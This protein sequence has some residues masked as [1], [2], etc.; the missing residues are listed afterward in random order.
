[1]VKNKSRVR[2]R[3]ISGLQLVGSRPWTGFRLNCICWNMHQVTH[4][5]AG[6]VRSRLGTSVPLRGKILLSSP[7]IPL[8]VFQHISVGVSIIFRFFMLLCSRHVLRFSVTSPLGYQLQLCSTTNF[9]FGDEEK[10]IVELTK[11]WSILHVLTYLLAFCELLCRTRH[12]FPSGGRNHHK[13]SLHLSTEGWPGWVHGPERSGTVDLLRPPN[14]ARCS[15]TIVDVTNTDASTTNQPP[16]QT[17]RHVCM[18]W[19][20]FF[21]RICINACIWICP[22]KLRVFDSLLALW[23]FKAKKWANGKF[24]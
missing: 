3:A 19:L 13:Y 1:M 15:L 10:I 16:V 8:S 22:Y 20:K 7:L 6:I 11:V 12:F 4:S 24:I 9:L 21:W 18:F 2:V 5:H 14:W 17:G 23:F